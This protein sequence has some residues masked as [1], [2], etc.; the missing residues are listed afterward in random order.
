MNVKTRLILTAL[1]FLSPVA[2][3][4]KMQAVSPA[5]GGG[6]PRDNTAVGD[7]ALLSLTLGRDNTA[8]GD[9]ALAS[10][11][12]GSFNTANGSQALYFN[13][14]GARNTA[15]GAY[16]L[17]HNTTG[18]NNTA[19]GFKA[20]VS[21]STGTGNTA[22]GES[23]LFHNTT[24]I[25][26]TANGIGALDSNTIGD[27]NTAT[28]AGALGN[29]STG[30]RNTALGYTAGFNLTTGSHN[31]YIGAGMTGVAGE[32]NACYIA[33]IFNQTSVSGIPVLIDSN[34]KLGTTTSSKRFKEE[35]KPMDK[36]SEGL[37][38]L[39]PVTFHYKKEIDPAGI[40]QFGLVAEEVEKV[41]PDL[42]V[43]D[44]EGKPCSVRYDQVNAMLLN[45]FLKEH[46]KFEEQE[47]IIGGL[48]SSAEE[49]AATIAE[50]KSTIAQQQKE[51]QATAA[52]QENEIQTLTAGLKQQALQMQRVSAQ[53]ALSNPGTRLA[54][55]NQ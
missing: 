53:F 23:A 15:T 30:T 16:A 20:L 25:R 24:G 31:V 40:A 48:K 7:N 55:D 51:F 54:G 11:T 22:N 41:N 3:L 1:A 47:A 17:F 9:V 37:Y 42:V 10:N 26:N 8:V 39:T 43:R 29:N 46:R 36:A 21:N 52:Q 50:L 34:N 44:K 38:A 13:T 32:S 19:N 27:E 12:T 14:T 4:P 45:E 35:I 5:P 6:Y 2:A 18:D 28:G 33:S 49:Q